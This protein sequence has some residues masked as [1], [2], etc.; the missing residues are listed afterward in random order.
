MQDTFW[1][2]LHNA[3]HWEF[4]I[5]LQV[6]DGVLFGVLWN[7]Y[8]KQQWRKRIERYK[9]EVVGGSQCVHPN[10]TSCGN[11]TWKCEVCSQTLLIVT[12]NQ[13]EAEW[14]ALNHVQ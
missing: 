8:L 10:V 6:V 14:K 3:A 12:K 4:E 7:K 9:R 1:T 5:F 13:F 2:L 11:G